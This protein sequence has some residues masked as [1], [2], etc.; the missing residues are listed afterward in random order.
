M[1][2]QLHKIYS[3]LIGIILPDYCLGCSKHD[4]SLCQTC[5][6]KIERCERDV[7]GVFVCYSY[8]DPLIRKAIWFLKYKNKRTL[9]SPL[10]QLIADF[11]LEELADQNIFDGARQTIICAIPQSPKRTRARG[12][13]Q[14]ELLAKGVAD[15][16][17]LIFE[18][19]ILIKVKETKR[20]VEMP[21]R[22]A[23]LENIKGVFQAKNKEFVRGKNIILIDDVV[24]TGA[25][26]REARRA[27]KEAGARKV[28]ACALA[29]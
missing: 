16:T 8:H 14:A 22:Q 9:T 19:Q 1:I 6:S 26:M 21:N 23:R 7:P 18:P 12:Y 5:I 4:I 17:G 29:H 3:T 11:V 13:N 28:I 27:L 20:Q 10:A 25:T 24:T 2:A 15:K